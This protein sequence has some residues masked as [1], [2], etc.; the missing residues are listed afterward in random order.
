MKNDPLLE[1]KVDEEFW[2]QI[3]PDTDLFGNIAALERVKASDELLVPLFEKIG[4]STTKG[5]LY[6]LA[7]NMTESEIHPE[8]VE[9]LDA[10]AEIWNLQ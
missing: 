6:Q 7:A 4:V 10:I 8:V 9:K 1:H 2:K 5:E 3:P